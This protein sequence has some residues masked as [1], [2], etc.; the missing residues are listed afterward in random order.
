MSPVKR[1]S[2]YKIE[3]TKKLWKFFDNQ[4]FHVKK[5]HGFS[6]DYDNN[7]WKIQTKEK[8]G[9]IWKR[10]KTIAILY[11]NSNMSYASINVRIIEREPEIN[12]FAQ[13]ME[14]HLSIERVEVD[15]ERD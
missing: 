15:I 14:A 3:R 11:V 7:F 4:E 9:M 12:D 8:H 13:S 10:R 2:A 6:H 1:L 5:Q